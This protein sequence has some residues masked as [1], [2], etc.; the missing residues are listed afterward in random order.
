MNKEKQQTNKSKND[1][2]TKTTNKQINK[3]QQQTNKNLLN[4]SNLK[5]KIYKYKK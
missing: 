5:L 2:Q 3:K 1:K 4:I